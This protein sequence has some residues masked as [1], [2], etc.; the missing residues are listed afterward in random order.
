M[1]HDADHK[2]YR[3]KAPL[4]THWE[5]YPP[6]QQADGTACLN[7]G[8]APYRTG[9][10][11]RWESLDEQQRYDATHCG[12]PY[13]FLE[14]SATEHLLDYPPGTPCFR[15]S[16][17]RRRIDKPE[18]FVVRD[19]MSAPRIHTRPEDWVDDLQNHTDRVQT[20]RERG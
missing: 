3:V 4:A 12:R 8:C 10:Q 2:T 13:Q 6:Q 11:L 7:S 14:V 15:A 5:P 20:A 9:W 19:G 1:A 17:H 18:I 16:T